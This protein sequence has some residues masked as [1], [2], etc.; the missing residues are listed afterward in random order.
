MSFSIGCEREAVVPAEAA[1]A[2]RHIPLPSGMVT[3]LF[4]DIE[5][6]TKLLK[7][8][9]DQAPGLFDRHNEIVRAALHTNRG[10]EVSTEGDAFFVAF[11]DTDAAL[12]ACAEIQTAL[13]AED[14]PVGGTVRVRMGI[15]TGAA[16][17][18][19]DNYVALA[20][21]QASR[22][23]SAA[24]GGQIVV[25]QTALEHTQRPPPGNIVPLGA[26][27]VRDFDEPERLH[28]LDPPDVPVV[29][30]PIRAL[31]AGGHNLVTPPTSFVGRQR[32]TAEIA[33]LL[34]TQQILTLVG[35][36]GRNCG[37]FRSDDLGRNRAGLFGRIG[38]HPRRRDALPT[39]L[40]NQR[41]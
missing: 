34:D 16:A 30:R 31:P 6:S 18:R 37:I 13:T 24:H 38:A 39:L 27:R 8:L 35:P 33:S 10:R 1:T 20:I 4:T 29:D 22:V 14:W 32:E 23:V 2:E 41:P 25:T 17:P 40:R 26:F 5:G 3:F 15:H 28:R 21:H 7:R 19:G 11:D 12:T 36:G 9:P